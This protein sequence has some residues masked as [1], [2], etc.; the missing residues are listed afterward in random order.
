MPRISRRGSGPG[1]QA[2]NAKFRFSEFG[3]HGWRGVACNFDFGAQKS[4]CARSARV[5]YSLLPLF[6]SPDVWDGIPELEIAG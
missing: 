5:L 3:G 1:L 4:A 2:F 6:R